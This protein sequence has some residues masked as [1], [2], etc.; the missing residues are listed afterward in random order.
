MC[1]C[2]DVCVCCVNTGQLLRPKLVHIA[3]CH[4]PGGVSVLI[5]TMKAHIIIII[6]YMKIKTGFTP[7][8]P[9][10]CFKF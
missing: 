10:L 3:R 8:Q 7:E 6:S 5:N 1:V 9:T 2:V 4:Y